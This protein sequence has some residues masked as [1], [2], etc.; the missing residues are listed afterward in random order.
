MKMTGLEIFKYLPASKKEAYSNCKK[1]GCPTC[2]MFA[3]KL[4][5]QSIEIDKC[6]H[7]CEELRQSFEHN[8][9]HPQKTIKI[10]DLN[11]GGENVLYRHE[12]KFINPT[13]IAIMVD[14][15]KPDYKDK[16][17]E[18]QN[19]GI[20]ILNKKIGIDLIILKNSKN[21][22]DLE[23]NKVLSFEQLQTFGLNI[24]EETDF[25]S[26]K[27]KLINIRTKAIVEK[28]ENYSAPTCVI[29]KN[30][31]IYSQCA[32]ASFYICKYA[33]MLIFQ[34]F[35]PEMLSSL[36]ML[37]Q[38]IFTDPEQNLQVEGGL[39]KFNNPDK[40]SIMFMTTNFALTFFAVS[41]ELEG[42]DISSYLIV[43]PSDGMSVLTAWSAQT[44]TPEIVKQT[45]DK[46]DIKNK[47]NTRKIIIPG[48][49]SDMCEELHQLNPEFEFL[50]GTKEASE[51]KD[52][53]QRL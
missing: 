53:V 18:I 34:E 42:L 21:I 16:I 39:Y 28:D 47:I 50:S 26:T 25:K 1:C 33:N 10:G 23:E 46:L 19:F 36:L 43:I 12:K 48:L 49:L 40:N 30:D 17:K 5:K 31:D 52:F 38:N 51:I 32:R 22:A 24:I 4:A 37:R 35:C 7:I 45:L 2:M 44:F 8:L 14:C 20:N 11:I 6:P 15:S 41:N 9:K 13:T 3:L 27:E 29:L